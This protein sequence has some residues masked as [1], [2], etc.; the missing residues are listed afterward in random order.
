V[1]RSSWRLGACAA[2]VA[3]RLAAWED[4]GFARRL[5]AKD[6]TLWSAEP[7]PELADRLGWLALHETARDALPAI[8]VLAREASAERRRHVVLLGMGGSSLAPE[9]FQR[10][11]GAA[12]GHPKLV[13]LDS[14]HP[15]AVRAVASH[16]DPATAL[17]LV[18]SKSGTTLETLSYFR[19][20]WS[21]AGR[22]LADPGRRFVAITDPGTP[23]E[24]LAR[25]RGFRAVLAAPPDVGGRYSALTAFGL[26][27]AAL[28]GADAG[29]LL[30]RAGRM[31]AACGPGAR[32][33]GNPGLALGAAL[34]ELALAGRDKLT[35]VAPGPLEALP[36]WLEQLIAESLGKSGTGIVPIADEPLGE[37]GVY[38]DDRAFAALSIAGDAGAGGDTRL[39]ALAAAGHPVLQFHLD[40]SLDLGAEML[41]W[42]IATAAAGVVLKVH[43]FDQPDVEMA[44]ALAR[45]AMK[46]KDG[47]ADAARA[48]AR[49]AAGG[50]AAGVDDPIDAADA[51]ALARAASAWL[52]SARPGDYVAI[53]AY[54]A[55]TPA[56]LARLGALRVALRDRLRLATTLGLG[57]RFLHST[58]QLHKGGP[59]GA[60]VLQIVDA[61]REDLAVPE[62]DFTFGALIGAQAQGDA[63]ALARRGRRVLRVNAGDDAT[64]GIARIAR[65]M[66][67]E[68]SH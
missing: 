33:A 37:P 12:P 64:A 43:P 50:E 52:A 4:E 8:E 60:L 47:A 1:N 65:G 53:Q 13:V 41:R 29:G 42:E 35:F 25:E 58:G 10:T 5:W 36:I 19:F 18:S 56:A 21:A 49:G 20:F 31:A 67:G 34:G 62:S 30:E 9:V 3:A 39:A 66:L 11:F 28:I 2:R 59:S 40:D 7:V 46:G 14:T 32:A 61:P 26:A 48:G 38:G 44:K 16:V 55:P 45:E 23:L 24:R 15:D 63:Q 6:T 51:A 68:S 22:A 17:F 27:P 57:P 54:V